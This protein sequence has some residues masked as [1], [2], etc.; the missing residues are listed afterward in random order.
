VNGKRPLLRKRQVDTNKRL[1]LYEWH[2]ARRSDEGLS[3]REASTSKIPDLL[4]IGKDTI[5]TLV[6]GLFQ[7]SQRNGCLAF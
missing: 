5:M 7:S 1:Q 3:R 6:H 4:S 2:H